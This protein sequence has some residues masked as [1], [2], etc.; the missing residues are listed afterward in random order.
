M[1]AQDLH[2]EKISLINWITR[3][4]DS[5]TIAKLKEIQ[6]AE[7]SDGFEV[8]EWHKEIVRGRISS[9][10]KKDYISFDDLDG[11]MSLDAE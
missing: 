9:T 4:Q 1:G 5:A 11:L 2:F 8:P 10:V 3:I 6:S 7:D